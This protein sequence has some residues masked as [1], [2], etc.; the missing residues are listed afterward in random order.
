M[1]E[2]IHLDTDRTSYIIDALPTGH[3]QNLYYGPR[4][5]RMADYEP[6]RQKNDVPYGT[7]VNVSQEHKN[8]GLDDQCLEYS[9]LGKGDY[10]EPAI[11]LV[12]AD[13]SRTTDFRVAS[14]R[15]YRGRPAIDGLPSAT[16]G[17]DDV[18]T[19][20]VELRDERGLTLTLHYCVY[21]AYDVITRF[22][23]LR[24]DGGPGAGPVRIGRLMSAQLDLFGGDLRLVTFDGCW[25]Y[26]RERHDK[27]L[28]PGVYVNDSKTGNSSNRHNPFVM[29]AAPDCGESGGECYAS[30]LVYS[31]NHAEIVERTYQGKTRL[32]TGV[33]PSGFEWLLEPGESFSTPE[34]VLSYSAEGFNGLS[35]NLHR[36]VRDRIVRGEWQYRERPVL[37][38]N[39]EATDFDFDRRKLLALAK[40]AADLGIELFVLDDGWFGHRDDDSSSLGDWE[41]NEKKLPGGIAGLAGKVN[42]LGLKFG[43][44]VEPE[45]ISEDSDLYRAHPDWAVSTPGR[46]PAYG[47]NQFVLDLTMPEVRA[48]LIEAM[49]KAFSQARIE[50]VKWDMNRNISDGYSKAL[51]PERQG[52]F[53]HRYILGL[54]E[55]LAELTKRFPGI[56]FESC[57]SGGNR[58]DLGMLCYMPQ[59]WTSDDTDAYA[60]QS[61]Q[62][63]TSYGYPPSAMGAHVSASPNMQTLRA[64]TIETRFNVA[65]FGL[66]GYELDLTMLSTFDK[67]AIKAQVAWYKEHRRLLQFGRFIRSR[68]RLDER[69]IVWTVV[70]DDGREAIAGLFQG[71]ATVGLGQDLLA[72]PGLDPE[73]DYRVAGRTQY[74][75][76]KAFGSLV[77]RVLPVKIRGD[78]VVH[79][80]LSEHYMF[81]MASEDYAVAGDLLSGYGVKLIQQFSGTGYNDRVRILSDYGSRIYLITTVR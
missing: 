44:W 76:V 21:A 39:W 7:M 70:S 49:T 31:G 11:E 12:F 78:G 60:R 66:L 50:Y 34:A 8:L 20:E 53:H 32:L 73:A 57:A 77:N 43:L 2:V 63:G 52:E 25:A 58:F 72:V 51:P 68:S 40:E 35:A 41:V 4:L 54:Y 65:A 9:S 18:E 38:N 14:T 67:K 17:E 61:I 55:V 15:S 59:T 26:E 46:A 69:K 36:F 75:N 56:L 13:G 33:N 48:Y 16:G 19:T 1:R 22:A 28:S 30:N 64:S 29:L 27:P 74:I 5:R 3:L 71:P 45:M 79:T 37:V 10:R 23:T 42:A 6:L 80:V 81:E 47:R 62:G 24:R